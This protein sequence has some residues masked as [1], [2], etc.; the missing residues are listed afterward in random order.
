MNANKLINFVVADDIFI[1]YFNPSFNTKHKM[2]LTLKLNRRM[3]IA[4]IV[5]IH[6]TL[7]IKYRIMNLDTLI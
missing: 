7:N 1:A 6:N 4:Y 5:Y 2:E 3:R